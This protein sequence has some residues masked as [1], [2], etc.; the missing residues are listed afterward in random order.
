MW[1]MAKDR[2][3]CAVSALLLASM[4]GC[5]TAPSSGSGPLSA[6]PGVTLPLPARVAVQV[7]PTMPGTQTVEFRGE[8]WQYADAELMQQ[9]ATT[10]FRK[11][12]AEVGAPDR[13]GAPTVTFQLNGSSSVNPVMSEYYANATA[14]IFQG[15]NTYVQPI[16]SLSGTGQASQPNFTRDGIAQAYESAF[17]QIA[18]QLL[19]DPNLVARLR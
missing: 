15:G 17:R 8:T 10:V 11:V 18:N 16:A 3:R 4:A 14:T 2:T 13:V 12:F 1:L 6:P 9:A 19:A 7:N 5:T